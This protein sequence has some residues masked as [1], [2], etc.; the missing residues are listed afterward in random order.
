MPNCNTSGMRPY[1]YQKR[2]SACSP[3]TSRGCPSAASQ[4]CMSDVPHPCR[5][6]SS[7][8]CTDFPIAMAYV[9]WQH[10][11]TT[12]ELDKA[13]SVGTIFPELDKPFLGKRGCRL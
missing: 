8:P 12:Y 3:S 11:S 4:P 10:F 1:T 9:P 7:R 2:P 6:E 5:T 13:L